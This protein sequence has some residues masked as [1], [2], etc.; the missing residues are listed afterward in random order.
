MTLTVR[1]SSRERYQP[2]PAN[3]RLHMTCESIEV[4]SLTCPRQIRRS[5][6]RA[7]TALRR[8]PWPARYPSERLPLLI[9]PGAERSGWV[10]VR[11]Q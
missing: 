10:G 5:D 3:P 6:A 4:T 7:G 2:E 1:A 11:A 8:I 9:I